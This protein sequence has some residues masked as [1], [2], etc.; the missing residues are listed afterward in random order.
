MSHPSYADRIDAWDH[1]VVC[2]SLLDVNS[3]LKS[4]ISADMSRPLRYHGPVS[5][6]LLHILE[7]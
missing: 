4:K 5:L 1:N 3:N 6:E 7:R 2:R